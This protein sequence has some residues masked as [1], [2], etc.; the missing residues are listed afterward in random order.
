M[1]SVPLTQHRSKTRFWRVYDSTFTGGEAV[2]WF[3]DQL[4][5]SFDQEISREQT[6]KLLGK[7]Y[8]VGVFCNVEQQE[9]DG[10]EVNE[11]DFKDSHMHIY[12]YLIISLLSTIYHHIIMGVFLK[13]LINN[14]LK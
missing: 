14:Y 12:R 5:Q 2:T 7:F 4:K 10:G 6:R 11:N 13:V 9:L 3:H 1:S 8:R